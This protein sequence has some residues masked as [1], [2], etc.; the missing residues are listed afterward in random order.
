VSA[1]PTPEQILALELPAND[2]GATTVRGY[3]IEL[4]RVL[5][6]EEEG[7]SGKH[8]FGNSGWAYDVYEPMVRAG[9]VQGTFYDDEG[10]ETVDTRAADA[11]MDRAIL[12]LG[13]EADR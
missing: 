7:F 3:L 9:W 11:L 13:E 12:A 1:D 8:P 6:R 2:S 4:L 5:W 10:L